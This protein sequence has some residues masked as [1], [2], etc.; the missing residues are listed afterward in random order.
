LALDIATVGGLVFG[1]GMLLLSLLIESHFNPAHLAAYLNFPGLLI[2][3]GGTGGAT[4]IGYTMK[5]MA[6]LPKVLRNAFMQKNTD[7]V[8]AVAMMVGFAGKARREGLLGLEEDIANIEDPFLKKGL[9]LVVDGTDMEMIR[10][11]LETDTAFMAQRHKTG[12]DIMTAAGGFAPTLGI[13]GAVAGLISALGTVS[14]ASKLTGAIAVAF[15][16]T[17]Y[18]IGFANLIFLPLS[19]KLTLR[20]KDDVFLRELQIVGILAISAGDNPRIVEEKMKAFMAPKDREAL[21]ATSENKE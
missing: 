14:D 11:I 2:I 18:G 1:W 16:A 12:A 4:L 10:E 6:N 19:A 9:Q 21:A 13:I 20:S 8:S 15:T 17:F 5:D 3:V 7:P